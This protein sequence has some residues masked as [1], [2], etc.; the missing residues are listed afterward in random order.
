MQR[1]CMALARQLLPAGC[2]FEDSGDDIA[3][4]PGQALGSA[5]HMPHGA[6]QC[7]ASPL[8][9]PSWRGPADEAAS[10]PIAPA[11]E[12]VPN[13]RWATGEGRS[14]GHS[15]SSSSSSRVTSAG[16]AGAA[17]TADATAS[18]RAGEPAAIAGEKRTKVML[19]RIPPTLDVA[20]VRHQLDKM[21]F[22]G[23]YDFV[24]VPMN[25]GSNLN[26][27]YAFVNFYRPE[28]AAHCIS[29]CTGRPFGDTMDE[30]FVCNAE[31]ARSQ[32]TT[33]S[34]H[35]APRQQKLGFGGAGR[36]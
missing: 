31:Y 18:T 35:A 2:V 30:T 29:S 4:E 21:G 27:R 5:A 28:D 22:R 13:P 17:P 24:H 23:R 36:W 9:A 3:S 8:S 33:A 6:L 15:Y 14:M 1:R 32:G 20:S 7:D 34:R 10:L 16:V 19:Q 11:V 25:H 26:M 12:L